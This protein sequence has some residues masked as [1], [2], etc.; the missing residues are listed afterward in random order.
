[1]AVALLVGVAAGGLAVFVSPVIAI[2]AV[3]GVIA[4]GLMLSSTQICLLA[5]I[6]IIVLLPFAVLPVNFGAT[7]SLLEASLLVLLVVWLLRMMTGSEERF[8]HSPLNIMVVIFIG[9]SLFSFVLGLSQNYDTSTIHNYF[10]MLLAITLFFAVLGTVRKREQ[11]DQLI[12]ALILAGAVSAL[13]G[14]ALYRIDHNLAIRLLSYLSVVGYPSG[15][16]VLRF[17]EDN[18]ALALRATS[19]SVDPNSFGGMMVVIM[20]L[21]V[22]QFFGKSPVLNRWL[23]LPIIGAVAA[24]I[25]LSNSRAAWLGTGVALAVIAT[26]KDRRLWLIMI[27]GLG[28]AVVAGIGGGF[29]SRLMAGLALQ[30]QATQMRLAEY[31]N[32]L[33]II[34]HYPWFGVGFGTTQDI[35]LTTGVSS[36]YLTIAERMGLAGLAVFL[37]TVGVFLVKAL[38]SLR[39]L[40]DDRWSTTQIGLI[41]AIAG[42]LTVGVLDHYYFNIEFPHMVA[43]FWLII[44]LGL[45]I[46]R[47]GAK[48]E[49]SIANAEGGQT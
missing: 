29:M 10:K 38:G 26:I 47:L 41:A 45:V 21:A 12:T 20:A 5:I 44:A 27:G 13:I 30:D 17:I 48:G 19:T 18:P 46:I 37:T 6:G 11:V 40:A 9:L 16:G 34:R 32:A 28:I 31:Q 23:L 25:L 15:P 2:A 43:L 22:T 49:D 39:R 3:L 36:I 8:E 14:L 33:D 4:L 24:C 1:M 42:A 35:T 7:A